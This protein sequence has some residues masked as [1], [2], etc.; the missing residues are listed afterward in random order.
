MI[1]T[2]AGNITIKTKLITRRR[3]R[4][5]RKPGSHHIEE[6][7]QR[8]SLKPRSEVQ[9]LRDFVAAQGWENVEVVQA[10][11]VNRG[12]VS[13]LDAWLDGVRRLVVVFPPGIETLKCRNNYRMHCSLSTR[14]LSIGRG[15]R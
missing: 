1:N 4:K 10:H 3:A 13:T 11:S 9:A 15:V 14:V 7:A 6:H 12:G 8:S 5:T 2:D